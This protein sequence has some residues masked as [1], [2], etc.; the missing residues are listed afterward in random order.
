MNARQKAKKYKKALQECHRL[1]IY[2][3]RLLDERKDLQVLRVG[4]SMTVDTYDLTNPDIEDSIRR[5]LIHRLADDE[6]FRQLVEFISRRDE[7]NMKTTIHASLR[8]IKPSWE[9]VDES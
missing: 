4:A 2:N 8:G 7:I 3:R 9:E 1:L 5:E 6:I